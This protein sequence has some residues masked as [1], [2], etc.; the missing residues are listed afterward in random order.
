MC[1]LVHL[2]VHT[3]YSLL[4][5]ASRVA[6][7]MRRAQELGMCA[8]ALSDHGNLFA[9]PSFYTE[10]EKAGLKPIIGCEFYIVEGDTFTRDKTLYHQLLLAK[11]EEGWQNL[12]YLSSISY[13]EGFYYKPRIHKK[14]LAEH[15]N[16]LIAT[17]GCLASEINQKILLGQVSE[18]EAVFRWYVELFGEDFYVELQDHGLKDQYTTA[19]YLLDW[20]QKYGV[21]VI[22]TNDVHYTCE[23]DADLHDLLLAIQTGS[24]YDDPKRF[25]FT[26][27]EGRLNRHFYL[28]SQAEM[29]AMP[30]FRARP[31][32]LIRTREVAEKCELKLDF[33]RPL[34]LPRYPIP[35]E[36]PDMDAYLSH[37]AYEGARRRYGELSPAIQERLDHELRII[38]QMGFAGYFL[39]VQDFVAEARQGGVWVGPGRGSAAGSLV[40]YVLGITN[41][42]PL[43]YQLLFER[44]L[45]PERVSPPDIDID[46]DDEGREEVIRYVQ[47]KYGKENVAQIITYGTMGIKT[48]IRD[49]GRTLKVPLSEVN[50]LASLIPNKPNI[51]W[52][53]ALE[54]EENPKAYLLKEYLQREGTIQKKLLETAA[55]L[56]GITRHTGVHAAGVI[57]APDKLW[58][59]VPLAIATREETQRQVITQWDGPDCE[60]VGL[61]KMDFLGLKTLSILK[62]AVALIQKLEGTEMPLDL[63]KIPLDDEK[64]WRLFQEGQ[65]IGIFQ[66]ESEG[67]QKYLR[68]L[69]PTCMEDLI[70]MNALYRPGPMDNIPTFVRRKHGE[71][72]VTYPDSRLRPILENTYGIM[73]YQEQ[74]M[75]IAQVMAGYS[76]AEADLLRRAMGKKKK[77]IMEEQRAIFIQRAIAHGTDPKVAEEVFDTMA[78]F[79]EY[80]FNKSHAA[81]YSLL[82]Y[83]TAYLKANYPAAYLAAVLTHHSEDSEKVGFFLQE[84]R[85][86]GIEVLPPCVN[87]SEVSFSVPSATQIRFGLGGIKHLGEKMAQLIVEERRQ[88]GKFKDVFDFAVRMTRQGMH[89]KAFESLCFA[90]ALD[91][92]VGGQREY[93]LE[94]GNRQVILEYAA[95]V[96]KPQVVA[97]ASLF[98]AVSF[99][100]PPPPAL[101]PPARRLSLPEK[102]RQE[103]DFIGYYL[104]SHPLDEYRELI[105]VAQLTSEASL[106]LNAEVPELRLVRAAALLIDADERRSRQGRPY[107]RLLFEDKAGTYT[108]TV[109][110]PQWEQVAPKVRGRMGDAFFLEVEYVVRAEGGAEWRLRTIDALQAAADMAFSAIVLE[111]DLQTVEERQSLEDLAFLVEQQ[112]GHIPV[113]LLL[114]YAQAMPVLV[115]TDWKLRYTPD[116]AE[117]F[118][119][120]GVRVR[121][122]IP[123]R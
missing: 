2:H 28:K 75:Q 8:I 80:G 12:L 97:Q 39:I 74:I 63:E 113:Y 29:A 122:D 31:E 66:F 83:R 90:G 36:F 79:A 111:W 14:L 45:N 82:A 81:A 115:Q 71:E 16:G 102:L 51:T 69:R 107:A 35:P 118:R 76:L 22:G 68:M 10:A 26:D 67:M 32:A 56:E 116:L 17:S 20:A 47:E 91:S 53:A 61:L 59:Y 94:E 85:A 9:V 108:L 38:R 100:P 93:L 60:R 103:R 6:D 99:A 1:D 54:A 123:V 87:E 96:N 101:R 58:K 7:L 49:V 105:R 95:S 109:F 44:F 98:D 77:E 121:T 33:N 106:L 112:K 92:L 19:K 110:S 114:H 46:F 21:K 55:Q 27:D 37:L 117:K 30:L 62:T 104:S 34:L 24:D 48:A 50:T 70:A 15:K 41:V 5:G 72:E 65:T 18:A 11:N 25:R 86:L 119:P 23:A 88:G 57:I 78:R 120:L 43:Q 42:D 3:E 64:T 13:L 84:V 89:K 40:A 4:D 52:G 73:V